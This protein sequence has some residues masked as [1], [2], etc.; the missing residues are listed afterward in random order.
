MVVAVVIV[1]DLKG[2]AL[3]FLQVQCFV[4][5]PGFEK[6]VAGAH[7]RDGSAHALH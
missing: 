2:I 7:C 1:I 6:T 5:H 3:A 4:Y